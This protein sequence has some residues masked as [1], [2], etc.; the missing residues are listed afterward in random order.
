MN[1]FITRLTP[2]HP[3]HQVLAKVPACLVIPQS[4]LA[5]LV[6]QGVNSAQFLVVRGFAVFFSCSTSRGNPAMLAIQ[7]QIFWMKHF[8]MT[9][10]QLVFQSTYCSGL[11]F[12]NH[13][14]LSA[15]SAVIR[16][17]GS[18]SSIRSNK[19]KAEDGIKQ[20]SSRKRRR[21]NLFGFNVWK[22]GNL[23]TEGHTAGVGV[24]QTRDILSSCINSVFACKN[25][26]YSS[27][28][29]LCI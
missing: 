11:I 5:V 9:L 21:C 20:N 29:V 14:D 17:S 15:S 8:N 26:S 10:L 27:Q 4:S 25:I 6:Y 2:Q 7:V 3:H 22:S 28:W 12:F 16:L 13:A 1:N 19:S 24:P 18:N 23:M